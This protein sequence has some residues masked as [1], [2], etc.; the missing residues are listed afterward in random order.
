M[1]ELVP[2]IY[3]EPIPLPGSP[4]KWINSYIIKEQNR[5]LLIDTAFNHA[6]SEAKILSCLSEIGLSI[7]RTDIFLT[8]MHV[9]HSGLC[10][11]LKR[12][13]NRVFASTRDSKAINMFQHP[14]YWDWIIMTNQ[15]AGV[16]SEHRLMPEGHVAFRYRPNREMEFDITSVGD[17]F[18]IGKY[19]FE[20]VDLKGHTPGQVGLF[21]REKGILFCGDHILDLSLIHI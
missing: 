3:M 12:P 5:G 13:S 17:H 10:E 20:V 6:E 2:N 19:A 1:K 18:H 11:R 4:L 9:D 7:D 21:D 14:P 8:H 15:Y 16:P